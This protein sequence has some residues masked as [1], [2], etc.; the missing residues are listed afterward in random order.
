MKIRLWNNSECYYYALTICHSFYFEFNI[1]FALL[2]KYQYFLQSYDWFA[3]LHF[4]SPC[5]FVFAL[6]NYWNIFNSRNT[7]CVVYLWHYSELFTF[8]NAT[9][10]INKLSF[11]WDTKSNK[12][13][14]IQEKSLSRQ[15]WILL[16]NFRKLCW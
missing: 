8:S 12:I 15:N 11:V 4:G 7:I 10:Q 9:I 2:W 1:R 5:T 6:K 16:T 14:Q 13:K 3:K